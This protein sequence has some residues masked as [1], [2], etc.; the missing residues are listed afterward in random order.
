LAAS[1]GVRGGTIL[2]AVSAA[3]LI[4]AAVAELFTLEGKLEIRH[5]AEVT[6]QRTDSSFQATKLVL[7]GGGFK[8]DKLPAG[9]YTV[10][11]MVAGLGEARR[12]VVLGPGLADSK[13]RVRS[14]FT[15]NDFNTNASAG[16]MV[17]MRLLT[18]PKEARDSYQKALKCLEKRDEACAEDRMLYA[19][20]IAPQYAEVWNHLGTMAYHRPDYKL[21]AERFRKALEADRDLYPA[22]VNLGGVSINLGDYDTAWQYNV[23][24]VLREPG[25]A[26]ANAQ[27]GM[28]YLATNR[29]ELAEKYLKE[30]IRLDPAHFSNPQLHL[31]EVYFRRKQWPIAADQ[32]EE[33]LRLRPNIGGAEQIRAEIVKLRNMPAK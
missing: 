25:D 3:V 33:L 11:V 16:Q 1:R 9:S 12:T 14:T 22:L 10:A 13:G 5:A 27:L 18:L 17:P 6:V 32:L 15:A 23:N 2:E 8:F 20:K 28:T 24:A 21:A 7:P 19:V 29:L 4:L 26:L 30:A 31:A